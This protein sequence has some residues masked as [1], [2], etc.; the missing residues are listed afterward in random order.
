LSKLPI[1]SIFERS[2][3]AGGVW[4]SSKY[5]YSQDNTKYNIQYGT[6][7][8]PKY[9]VTTKEDDAE[10]SVTDTSISSTGTTSN[11]NDD[12]H[13]DN[14]VRV[15]TNVVVEDDD[16]IIEQMANSTTSMYEALWTNAPS[17][18][19]EYSDYSFQEHFK[20]ALPIYLHCAPLLEYMMAQVT[21]N[22][23]NFFQNVKF[24]INVNNVSNDEV[25]KK[26]FLI[27][28]DNISGET[29]VEYFDKCI[30]AAG[31]NGCAIIPKSIGT[32]LHQGNFKGIDIHSSQTGDI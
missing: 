8:N 6:N 30:W 12:V 23:P 1:I 3:T 25:Q 28:I 4:K 31:L 19:I 10:L 32:T 15:A 11:R 7:V 13:I 9:A 22:N 27:L 2:S 18:C 17:Q 14:D 29:S 16:Y 21:R 24:N 26:F 20:Q 5:S